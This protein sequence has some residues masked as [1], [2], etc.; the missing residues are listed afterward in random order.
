[1][2]SKLIDLLE[3]A[4]KS[5]IGFYSPEGTCRLA[6]YLL[7][8]GVFVPPYKIGDIVYFSSAN[9][10]KSGKIVEIY[11]NGDGFSFG[12]ELNYTTVTLQQEEV[13]PTPEEAEQAL[14][15]DEQE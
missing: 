5:N 1:M 7:R 13:Y 9:Q 8:N 14:K 15:G 6:D 4:K 2:R 12:V 11:T 10:I 3:K